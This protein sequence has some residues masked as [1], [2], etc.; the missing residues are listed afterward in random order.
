MLEPKIPGEIT[1]LGSKHQNCPKNSQLSEVPIAVHTRVCKSSPFITPDCS[2]G[3]PC[4]PAL[5][6]PRGSNLQWWAFVQ[7]IL[8][9]C[10]VIPEWKA[11][12]SPHP[13]RSSPMVQVWQKLSGIQETPW[14]GVTVT[15][16]RRERE[17]LSE[18]LGRMA[19][20]SVNIFN[21]CH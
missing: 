15:C 3:Q 9:S 6:V 18:G 2:P 1:T 7:L 10:C 21:V 16:G 8:S 4:L 11:P 20:S 19:K 5:P 13:P 17:S 14:R 12:N